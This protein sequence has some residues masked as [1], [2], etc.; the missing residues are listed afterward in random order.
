MLGSQA[1]PPAQ[2]F[3]FA[4]QTVRLVRF[5]QRAIATLI[6]CNV[7]LAIYR[8]PSSLFNHDAMRRQFLCRDK[9]ADGLKL[10]ISAVYL[11]N[12]DFRRR[13]Y[14]NLGRNLA[15][16]HTSISSATGEKKSKIRRAAAAAAALARASAGVTRIARFSSTHSKGQ[17][18]SSP[19]EQWHHRCSLASLHPRCLARGGPR[20]LVAHTQ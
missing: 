5:T 19:N 16:A 6:D 20:C 8:W 14:C 3:P 18:K 7:V 15:P 10:P 9:T 1:P 4:S 2:K 11:R 17:K 12:A 13:L